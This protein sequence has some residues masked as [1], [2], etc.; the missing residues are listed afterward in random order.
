MGRNDWAWTNKA[1]NKDEA[2]IS[3]IDDLIE[4]I[5]EVLK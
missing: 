2:K 3:Q 5:E 1:K 4:M